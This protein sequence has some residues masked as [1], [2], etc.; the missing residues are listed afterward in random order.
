MR[1]LFTFLSKQWTCMISTN[2]NTVRVRVTVR[3]VHVLCMTS[4]FKFTNSTL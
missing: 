1:I 3:L 4:T 2:Q